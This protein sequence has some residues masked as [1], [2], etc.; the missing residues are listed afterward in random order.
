MDN[1]LGDS[2]VREKATGVLDCNFVIDA[3]AGSGKTTLI[4]RRLLNLIIDGEVSLSRIVAITFTKKAAGQLQF[5]IKELLEKSLENNS[6][7]DYKKL[8]I[9]RALQDL[10]VS[11]ISTIHSFCHLML[12]ERPFEANLDPYF[13]ELDD[14]SKNK[15]IQEEWKIFWERIVSEE[16]E[17]ITNLLRY[18]DKNIG[19]NIMN[20]GMLIVENSDLNIPK[21]STAFTEGTT[22][23]VES[24]LST[25]EQISSMLPSCIDKSD[26]GYEYITNDF[27]PKIRELEIVPNTLLVRHLKQFKIL[28]NKGAMKNWSPKEHITFIKEELTQLKVIIE[29][30]KRIINDK[31]YQISINLAKEFA[32]QFK[33]KTFE[34]GYLSYQDTLLYARNLLRDNLEVRG[35]FQNKFDVILV[36]EFQDTDPLQAEIIFFLSEEEPNAK[37][38]TDVK[39]KSGK[40]FIV[41]DPKQ[42]IY[43]FRRA[44]I[45]IYE[46]VK[47]LIE[48]NEGEVL[49]L[50]TNFRSTSNVIDYVN[51]TFG[52]YIKKPEDGNY[53]PDYVKL[54]PYRS[55]NLD[56]SCPVKLITCCQSVYSEEQNDIEARRQLEFISVARYL[57]HVVRDKS[58]RIIKPECPN[59]EK[60]TDKDKRP[61]T[62]ADVLILTRTYTNMDLL[63]AS[64][65]SFDIPY[66][67]IG[68]KKYFTTNEIRSCLNLLLALDNPDD[69]LSLIAVLKGPFFGHSDEALFLYQYTGGELNFTK[70]PSKDV[71]DDEDIRYSLSIINHVATK[72]NE[73][74]PANILLDIYNR[75]RFLVPISL[76][77]D[78]AQLYGNLFK[79]LELSDTLSQSNTITFSE[80]VDI[81]NTYVSHG[82]EEPDYLIREEEE[83]AVKVM[84]I[85]KAKGLEAP[86][87]I[88]IDTESGML[89][90]IDYIID[91]ERELLT[92]RISKDYAPLQWDE[93]VEDEKKRL[94][95]EEYRL[96]YVTVT[97]AR[98][99]FITFC[100]HPE[101]KTKGGN[102][103]YSMLGL[104]ELLNGSDENVEIITY[105]DIDDFYSSDYLDGID[106]QIIGQ[107]EN[108]FEERE[109]EYEKEIRKFKEINALKNIEVKTP[110]DA[111]EKVF[112]YDKDNY[113][114]EKQEIYWGKDVG[115]LIHK[116]FEIIDFINE[117]NSVE[118]ITN[119]MKSNVKK[120]F[121]KIEQKKLIDD[122]VFLISEIKKD[123]LW[124][125]IKKSERV[126]RE[127]P[128]SVTLDGT[129]YRGIIDLV[130]HSS[131]GWIIVDYKTDLVN[132]S[133]A[134]K[135]AQDYSS[136]L[137][138]YKKAFQQATGEHV[139]ESY[140]WFLRPNI[141]VKAD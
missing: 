82:Y 42:S 110:T 85:H 59:F 121:T 9:K 7:P 19:R 58:L 105:K 6:L 98:D 8:L 80:Y 116:I 34:E 138:I 101:I 106:K 17:D 38:Y 88:M 45:E 62:Y 44:D 61:V 123:H 30:W 51:Y 10:Q 13:K 14:I 102:A 84:T 68:N 55:E 65:K 103:Y 18:V 2:E 132:N 25:A 64:L 32:D 139:A 11:Y 90:R 119:L 49:D 21:G 66:T 26:K 73:V 39:L 81:L 52:K 20:L 125:E 5:K 71:V 113:D 107:D 43:R 96:L 109:K 115:K 79:L 70:E 135:R 130:Y 3:G 126:L 46:K 134:E 28:T 83:D 48:K 27:L 111:S 104:P 77:K 22:E 36:D 140:I 92:S 16:R 93:I 40:L 33:K 56:K 89:G 60:I 122:I 137:K 129:C 67:V 95:A 118:F 133:N 24:M 72:K 94:L 141:K 41:G 120:H 23:L 87:V 76:K 4:T 29:E 108:I 131:K 50:Q 15:L 136:Q 124:I 37:D 91:R 1:R 117:D 78:R 100:H 128:F 63:E 114:I 12:S 86:V 127:V 57:N 31:V 97:R 54:L 47:K 99:Y 35:Y 69:R 112:D 75:T 74:H 53:Q